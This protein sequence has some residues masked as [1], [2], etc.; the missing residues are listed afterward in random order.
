MGGNVGMKCK[1]CHE[2]EAVCPDYHLESKNW[3]KTICTKCHAKI[4]KNDI[5]WSLKYETY[6]KR[7]QEEQIKKEQKEKEKHT[8]QAERITE[9]TGQIIP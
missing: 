6:V 5:L 7:Q 8:R 3:Y 2:N 9:K 4:V 1:F